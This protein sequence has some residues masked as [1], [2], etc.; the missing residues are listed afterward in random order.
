MAAPYPSPRSGRASYRD[1]PSFRKGRIGLGRRCQLAKLMSALGQ[2]QTSSSECSMS[3]LLPIADINRLLGNV[4][5]VPRGDIHSITS[6]ARVSK[7]GGTVRPSAF[8]AFKLITSSNFVGCSTGKSPGLVPFRI[9]S[10][11]ADARWNRF[12]RIDP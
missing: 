7:V 12:D 8:A 1:R 10:T 6:S 4:R 11:Y 3:A 9:L 5:L 2:K